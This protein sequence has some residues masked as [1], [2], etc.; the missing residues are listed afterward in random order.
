MTVERTGQLTSYNIQAIVKPSDA[1]DFFSQNS[2]DTEGARGTE[3]RYTPSWSKWHGIYRALPEYRAVI[4]KLASWTFGKGIIADEKNKA[5]LDRIKGFGKDSARSVLKNMWRTAMIC[6]DSFAEIIK[7]NQGRIT[8]L[9]P[10][11]PGSITIVTNKKG[12]IDRYEQSGSNQIFEKDEIYHL[13]YE[14]IADEIHGIPFGEALENLI[15]ARNEA[16]ED[17]RVLYHRNIKPIH[18]IEVETS[19]TTQLSLIETSINNAYKKTENI[20]IPTGVI[21]EIKNQS[22]PQYSTLDSLPYIKFLVREFVTSCGVPEVVMGWGENTTEASSKVIY[23]A[24]QQEIEDMQLYNEEQVKSQLNIEIELEFPVDLSK[25]SNQSVGVTNPSSFKK[26]G[27]M[28]V[29][30]GDVKL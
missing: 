26:D 15:Y 1:K 19:D 23:L 13:S 9:K 17:L 3:F 29:R 25:A 12:I 5:K 22:T 8:N 4:N 2:K 14:R 7:D 30:R 28:G 18:W 20:I 6:G 10:L 24:F 11:N 21:K 27:N 16:L